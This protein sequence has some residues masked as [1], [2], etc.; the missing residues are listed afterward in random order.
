MDLNLKKSNAERVASIVEKLDDQEQQRALDI[1]T[2]FALG[3]QS[4]KE[5]NKEIN[6]SD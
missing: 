5:E 6:R 1:I 3:V 2:S 4:T